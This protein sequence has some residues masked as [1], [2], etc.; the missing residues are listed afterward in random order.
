[1]IATDAPAPA[2]AG[3]SAVAINAATFVITCSDDVTAK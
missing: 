2:G 1:M 3:G